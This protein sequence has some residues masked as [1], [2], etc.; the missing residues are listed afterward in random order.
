MRTTRLGVA[1]LALLVLSLA[2]SVT[3]LAESGDAFVVIVHP[4]NS[5]TTIDRGFLQAAYLN[6]VTSWSDGTTLAPIDLRA[7]FPAR[8]RF[9]RAVLKKTPQQLKRYWSQQIFSGKGVPPPEGEPAAVIAFVVG[10]PG[11]VGYL[12]PGV[13]PGAAKVVTLR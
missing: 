2:P 5:A 3:S 10:H 12:P 7:S 6:K 11:A 13:D 9:T 4:G 8:E 1:L